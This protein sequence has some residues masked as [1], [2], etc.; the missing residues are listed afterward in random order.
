MTFVLPF[1]SPVSRQTS[2]RNSQSSYEYPTTRPISAQVIRDDRHL[3]MTN[4]QTNARPASAHVSRRTSHTLAAEDSAVPT[5]HGVLRTHQDLSLVETN[6][7]HQQVSLQKHQVSSLHREDKEESCHDDSEAS[8]LVCSE[9]AVLL[10]SCGDDCCNSKCLI[11]WQRGFTNLQGKKDFRSSQ[12]Q[13]VHP[14]AGQDS[15]KLSAASNRRTT[16]MKTQE[17]SRGHHSRSKLVIPVENDTMVLPK[18]GAAR[19]KSAGIYRGDLGNSLDGSIRRAATSTPLQSRRG[20]SSHSQRGSLNMFR[21]RGS[22][23]NISQSRT[24]SVATSSGGHER[25]YFDIVSR[26]RLFSAPNVGGGNQGKQFPAVSPRAGEN[27]GIKQ[28]QFSGREYLLEQGVHGKG[29]VAGTPV[30]NAASAIETRDV[31]GQ[32]TQN[33]DSPGAEQRHDEREPA[34]QHYARLE[35]PFPE[36]LARDESCLQLKE[37]KTVISGCANNQ[38]SL[39]Q[40]HSKSSVLNTGRDISVASWA[41]S[42]VMVERKNL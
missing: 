10:S 34:L 5:P 29:V 14:Q 38:E 31:P 27:V 13:Q 32:L 9:A 2:R 1:S 16:A 4:P 25:D 40:D 21:S 22:S 12:Q 36:G 42:S 19:P 17:T 15:S 41:S 26:P 18:K 39:R 37:K 24:N 3:T 33:E 6:P 11:P 7:R 35:Q 20:A 30:S 28:Q 23:M 8:G